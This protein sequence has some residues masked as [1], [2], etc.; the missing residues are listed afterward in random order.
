MTLT[1]AALILLYPALKAR[2]AC[3]EISE[4]KYESKLAVKVGPVNGKFEATVELTD[5]IW[6]EGS[7]SRATG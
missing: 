4:N 5:V 1:I 7:E 6:Y 3:N 2:R